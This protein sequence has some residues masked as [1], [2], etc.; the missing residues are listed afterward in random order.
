MKD[1]YVRSGLACLVGP[2]LVTLLALPNDRPSSAIVAVLFVLAVVIA[3]R[4]GGALAGAGTS[5]LS[6]LSLNFFFT[7]PLHTLAVG[8]VQDLV[9]LLVFLVVS[10]IVGVLLSS[11]VTAKAKAERRE[12]ELR[13]LNRLATRLLSGE[14]LDEVLRG[15]AEGVCDAFDLAACE[16]STSFTD[17]RA[18]VV[19]QPTHDLADPLDLPLVARKQEL[20]LVRLWLGR[21]PR[22]TEDEQVVVRSLATQ[23]ALALEGMRLTVEVRRAELE[24]HASHLKAALFS[25]VTHDVKTPLAAIT[26]AVTSLI[27]GS[28][29]SNADRAAH[30]DTIKQEAERLH[31]VVNNLLDVARLRAGALVPNKVTTPIEE[32]VE[33]VINRLRPLLDGRDVSIL[34]GEDTP[35]VTVDVVQIDQVLTN[36][37]ENATKFTPAGSP[38][39][40]QVVGGDRGVRVTVAD[41]GPG[42]PKDDRDLIFE[43][44]ERRDD[45]TAGTG[46]G[47][48][49]AR[50]VMTAH[51]GRIWASETPQGGAAF[52]FELPAATEAI[53][54]AVTDASAGTRS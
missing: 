17:E 1:R 25:G 21:R 51:G 36:L 39:S 16:V 53:P 7:P 27:D 10:V 6:F 28:G 54:E 30:L 47:L 49:I 5:L 33:S 23:L 12:A 46:L 44:F 45:A 37:L 35:E 26:T 4:V 43:P 20:G 13:L 18:I 9:A 11:A 38:I 48:A 24:A 29:F 22:L 2:A 8:K 42:I 32:L 19:R 50:A 14:P 31:R 41:A 15:F 40:V 52:T 34:V 3:A